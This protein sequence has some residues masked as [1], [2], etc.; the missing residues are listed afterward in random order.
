MQLTGTRIPDPAIHE[1]KHVVAL[2]AQLHEKPKPKKLAQALESIR[3]LRQLPNVQLMSSRYTPITK[4]K[5]VGRWK[6]IVK[7]LQERDLPVTGPLPPSEVEELIRVATS[8][9]EREKLF[10]QLE[11]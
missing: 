10:R 5:E 9:L 3:E 1:I 8:D 6:V 11:G 7:E 2:L 4:E